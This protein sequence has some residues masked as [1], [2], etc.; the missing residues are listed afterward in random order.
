MNLRSHLSSSPRNA[1]S[2][3]EVRERGGEPPV[4][5][6]YA[7]VALV[8]VACYLNALGGDFVH[9][10]IPAVVRNKDVLAQTPLTTLLKNDFWGTPMRD[11]NSHKSY[12][13]LTTLTFRSLKFY[14][15]L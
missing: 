7:T 4:W 13:P 6:I 1:Q 12:R 8:A 11:V 15:I 9:D 3:V 2:S 5:C 14:K 10:D